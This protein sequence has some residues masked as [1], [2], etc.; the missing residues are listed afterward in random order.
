MGPSKEGKGWRDDSVVQRTWL[1]QRTRGSIPS[2]HYQSP[3]DPMPLQA[4]YTRCMRPTC[5]KIPTR[6][7]IIIIK[8]LKIGQEVSVAKP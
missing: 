6:K 1:F 3:V 8:K 5:S 7:I 2:T 4:P